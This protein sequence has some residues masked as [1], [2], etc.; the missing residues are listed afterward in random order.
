VEK[1]KD[2]VTYGEINEDTL[3][4]LIEKR[5][6]K[7]KEKYFFRLHPPRGG[8]ERKGT[9]VSYK[10]GGAVGYRG[11]KINDLIRRMM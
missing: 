4:E 10:L 2:L 5:G 9:K 1:V 11:D 6:K 3:K 8:F 7:I